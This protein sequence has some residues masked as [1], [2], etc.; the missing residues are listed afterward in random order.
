MPRTHLHSCLCAVMELGLQL[1]SHSLLTGQGI[2][3]SR[4]LT[5]LSRPRFRIS[6]AGYA[7][8]Q[9]GQL[10]NCKIDARSKIS[11]GFK[12]NHIVLC[13]VCALTHIRCAANHYHSGRFGCFLDPRHRLDVPQYSEKLLFSK[14]CQ[15]ILISSSLYVLRSTT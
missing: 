11:D 13:S 4:I 9:T 6:V 3:T 7:P 15:T 8:L 14:L 5:M 12:I 1:K 2:V 10:P